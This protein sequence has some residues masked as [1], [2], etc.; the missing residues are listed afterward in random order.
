MVESGG[1]AIRRKIEHEVEL[2][3]WLRMR[4]QGGYLRQQEEGQCCDEALSDAHPKAP[5]RGGPFCL[6]MIFFRKSPH[7]SLPRKRGRD[8][9]WGFRDHALIRPTTTIGSS[10]PFEHRDEKSIRIGAARS[11]EQPQFR[12]QH[13]I[14]KGCGTLTQHLHGLLWRDRCKLRPPLKEGVHLVVVLLRQQRT[15][16]VDKSAAGF[17]EIA[18]AVERGGLL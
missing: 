6:S 3:W 2:G 7:P 13:G 12:G 4:S 11:H 14:A 9:G 17:D 18:G 1:A 10:L 8:K 15:G 5:G 16:D